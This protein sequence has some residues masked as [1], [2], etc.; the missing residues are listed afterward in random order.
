MSAIAES[1]RSAK[2]I[3]FPFAVLPKVPFTWV[4]P[5]VAFA[6]ALITVAASLISG[7]LYYHFVTDGG[8]HVEAPLALGLVVV[9]YF[10]TLNGYRRNYATDALSDT[11]RQV[12]EV[13]VIW[14]LVFVLLASVAFLLKIDAHFSHGVALTFFA[15][16][17]AFL[18]SSRLLLAKT[19]VLARA[20]WRLR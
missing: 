8:D 10:V 5:A 6:D 1:E 12:R 16:G 7:L 3:P 13:S 17:W 9:V 4:R 11:Y 14:C 15:M 20:G 18:I 19:L 2:S